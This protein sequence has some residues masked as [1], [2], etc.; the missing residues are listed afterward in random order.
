V[1]KEAGDDSTYAYLV[2]NVDV[3]PGGTIRVATSQDPE[4][5]GLPIGVQVL[6]NPFGER[7][8]LRIMK[9]LERV[10][11]GYQPPPN[12]PPPQNS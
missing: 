6:G 12:F 9:E 4:T 7:K 11:G 10:F 1:S 3:I 5:K 2:N 8:V